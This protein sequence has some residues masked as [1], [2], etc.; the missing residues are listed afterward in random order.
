[1]SIH[2]IGSAGGSATTSG[3]IA[4]LLEKQ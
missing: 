2:A 3:W 1:V 4:A